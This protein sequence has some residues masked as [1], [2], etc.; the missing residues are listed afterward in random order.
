MVK[1]IQWNLSKMYSL[2]EWLFLSRFIKENRS[3]Q[4]PL[5]VTVFVLPF[6]TEVLVP[7]NYLPAKAEYADSKMMKLLLFLS[8]SLSL[9]HFPLSISMHE[10]LRYTSIKKRKKRHEATLFITV[11][12]PPTDVKSSREKGERFYNEHHTCT[13]RGHCLIEW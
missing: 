4:S 10:V 8:L 12:A 5:L 13:V 3:M 2:H 6:K 9:I 11:F 1:F 7:R